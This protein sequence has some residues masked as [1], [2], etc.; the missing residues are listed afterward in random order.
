M[1]FFSYIKTILRM[2]DPHKKIEEFNKFYQLF[3][4]LTFEHNSSI[5]VWHEPSYSEICEIVEP[6]KLAKRRSLQ[7]KE[8]RAIFLHAIAHIEY[9]AIDLALD[10][11]YRFRNMP[12]QFYKDWIEV[13]ADECRHFV[14]IEDLLVKLGY[15]YGDFPVH[16][17][18]FDAALHSTTLLA[19]MS[20]VPRYL[21]AN[22][23]D[24]NAKIIEKLKQYPDPFA[25]EMVEA[26]QLI[27]DEEID[28][29][30]KGDYWFQWACDRA[31][32]QDYVN[33]Y[34]RQVEQIYPQTKHSKSFLNVK[35]RLQ[36]GFSCKEI[37]L[38]A[39]ER[40]DCG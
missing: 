17:G 35:A 11:A 15:K 24:A 25:K 20:V 37:E 34:F 19:R 21:E 36:A 29:V 1:E 12:L 40:V 4:N 33:E 27:L 10:A 32:I 2:S 9:S 8:Q 13:A 22:G 23:L 26:L 3:T 7:T 38:L 31:G 30:K 5:E 6:K 39:K 18:L 28:H 16:R 14:M